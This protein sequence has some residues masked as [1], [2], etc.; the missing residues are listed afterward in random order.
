MRRF[1]SDMDTPRSHRLQMA[2]DRMGGMISNCWLWVKYG[3][4]T[5]GHGGLNERLKVGK[6]SGIHGGGLGAEVKGRTFRHA[7]A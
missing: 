5:D 1:M 2:Q 4:A 6:S 7:V 3:R